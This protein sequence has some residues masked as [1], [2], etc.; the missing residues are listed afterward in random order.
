MITWQLRMLG[1]LRASPCR[2]K[3]IFP[4]FPNYCSFV[5]VKRSSTE[6]P[7][8]PY[9]EAFKGRLS[10]PPPFLPPLLALLL[11][12]SQTLHFTLF[13]L[14]FASPYLV[15]YFKLDQIRTFSSDRFF[16]ISSDNF[17]KMDKKDYLGLPF[18]SPFFS[19]FFNP[20][21]NLNFLRHLLNN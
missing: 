18:F 2:K 4:M 21:K 17:L 14:H 8:C 9:F 1:E 15:T 16:E 19:L 13:F 12:I 11:K 7:N 20:Q 5:N 10:P 6:L 3:W